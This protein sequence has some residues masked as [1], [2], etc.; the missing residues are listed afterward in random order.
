VD[1]SSGVESAPGVKDET[2][3]AGFAAAVRAHDAR[4]AKM[5]N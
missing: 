2:L 1:L 4:V 3:I 5:D